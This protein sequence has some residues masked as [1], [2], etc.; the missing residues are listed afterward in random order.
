MEQRLFAESVAAV[1]ARL[2]TDSERGL[3]SAEASARL[4]EGGPNKL[5][6]ASPPPW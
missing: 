5:A 6:E 2:A 1:V 4:R 3:T